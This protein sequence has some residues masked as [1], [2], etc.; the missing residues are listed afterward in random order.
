[1]KPERRGESRLAKQIPGEDLMTFSISRTLLA[2]ALTAA[3]STSAF[4]Q[5]SPNDGK[6]MG[7]GNCAKNK[8]NCADTAN[9][10][11][12]TDTVWLEKMTWMDVRDAMKAGKKTI[13]IPTGGME[14]NG[15]WLTLGKHNWVLETNCEA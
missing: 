7:G 1:D 15:P 13:I 4:A 9:P 5:V 14:P 2:A 12:K 8:Y 11:P 10:L 3:V 6:S